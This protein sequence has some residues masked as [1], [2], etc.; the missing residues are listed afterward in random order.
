MLIASLAVNKS[1]QGKENLV[2]KYLQ[3]S[4]NQLLNNEIYDLGF[5]GSVNKKG[6][7]NNFFIKHSEHLLIRK[8]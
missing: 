7:F 2:W 5:L 1:Y 8:V 3:N 4:L 6:V